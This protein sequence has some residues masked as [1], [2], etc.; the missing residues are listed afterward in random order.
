MFLFPSLAFLLSLKPL[1]TYSRV[2]VKIKK[3]KLKYKRKKLKL[4]PLCPNASKYLTLSKVLNKYL[5]NVWAKQELPF[6]HRTN[7]SFNKYLLHATLGILRE[8]IRG[9]SPEKEKSM[10]IN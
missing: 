8:T 5:L 4:S 7:H 1:E 3:N 9:S 6:H 10:Y 2:R